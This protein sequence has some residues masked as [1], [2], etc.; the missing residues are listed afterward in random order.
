VA[1]GRSG[2]EQWPFKIVAGSIQ[3]MNPLTTFEAFG[4][5]PEEQ[6]RLIRFHPRLAFREC[7]S[8]LAIDTPPNSSSEPS[9]AFIRSTISLPAR[10]IKSG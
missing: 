5:F 2:L 10:L 1:D 7:S 8:F 3:M 4:S 6:K 9:Q